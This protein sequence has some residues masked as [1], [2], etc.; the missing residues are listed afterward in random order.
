MFRNNNRDVVWQIGAI[1]FQPLYTV[2]NITPASLEAA[3]SIQGAVE[4]NDDKIESFSADID[5]DI[6]EGATAVAIQDLLQLDSSIHS[7]YNMVLDLED[8]KVVESS[9]LDKGQLL[10]MAPQGYT[11]CAMFDIAELYLICKNSLPGDTTRPESLLIIRKILGIPLNAPMVPQKCEPEYL[12]HDVNSSRLRDDQG[13][14]MIH[15]AC[16]NEWFELVQLLVCLAG[17]DVNTRD[18]KGWSPIDYSYARRDQSTIGL[19]H[20]CLGKQGQ[21]S[22]LETHGCIYPPDGPINPPR[23]YRNMYCYDYD[24][25]GSWPKYHGRD[26]F[27]LMCLTYRSNYNR[28]ASLV[29]K[30]ARMKYHAELIYFWTHLPSNTL[31][32]VKFLARSMDLK[33]QAA[34]VLYTL[35]ET[36]QSHADAVQIQIAEFTNSCRDQAASTI[37]AVKGN[38]QNRADTVKSHIV[39]IRADMNTK[40]AGVLTALKESCQ[41]HVDAAK[42]HIIET[43]DTCIDAANTAKNLTDAVTSHIVDIRADMNT[44]AAGVLTALKE[45]CQSHVDAAKIHIIET[46]DTCIDAVKNQ[47]DAA[48]TRIASFTVTCQSIIKSDPIVAI[49]TIAQHPV[50][51]LVNVTSAVYAETTAAKLIGHGFSAIVHPRESFRSL[52]MIG[53]RAR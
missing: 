51:A 44:K 37:D 45:S 36:C 40:A 52:L 20:N 32:E 34:D 24:G 43:T 35:K 23:Q 11:R 3:L 19:L 26:D 10:E 49:S 46:T 47:T 15:W 6:E 25:D 8:E 28:N 16:S 29:E 12:L 41:S 50:Q 5:I 7:I 48:T 14:H 2:I 53:A 22:D 31:Y 1:V 33:S 9:I 30:A 38:C 39:D 17:S 27:R 42:I 4:P 13:M 18:Y 21:K